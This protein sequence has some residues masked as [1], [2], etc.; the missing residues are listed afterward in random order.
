MCNNS[1]IVNTEIFQ[2]PCYKI[3]VSPLIP[4]HYIPNRSKIYF[5]YLDR[6][7]FYYKTVLKTKPQ[8][9]YLYLSRPKTILKCIPCKQKFAPFIHMLCM[10][11]SLRYYEF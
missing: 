6:Q 4:P 1:T 10:I 5:Q 7:K 9:K 2:N 11:I 3:K 8:P